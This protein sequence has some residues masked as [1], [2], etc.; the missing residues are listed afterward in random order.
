MHLKFLANNNQI[1]H[2]MIIYNQSKNL[3]RLIK[4]NLLIRNR[5]YNN[6]NYNNNKN[7]F[8]KFFLNKSN[9]NLI[10]KKLPL[11]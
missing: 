1:N 2:K 10:K 3:I 9:N 7:F 4:F 8:H 6:N 5:L 11:T